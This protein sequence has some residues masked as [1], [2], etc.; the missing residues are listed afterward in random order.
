M[1]RQIIINKDL[2]DLYDTNIT[3]YDGS[4]LSN[5]GAFGGRDKLVLSKQQN[6]SVVL[7]GGKFTIKD[8]AKKN[9]EFKAIGSAELPKGT[10]IIADSRFFGMNFSGTVSI[11]SGATAIF[12]NCFFVGATISIEAGCFAHFIGVLFDENTTYSHAGVAANV[13]AIGV[14]NKTGAVLGNTTI[15]AE[16]L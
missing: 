6:N 7:S 13:Y 15:V 4:A 9:T 8:V 1:S 3:D 2:N 16:T 14:S 12:T 10:N 5:L 11:S